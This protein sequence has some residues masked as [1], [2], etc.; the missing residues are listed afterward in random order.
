MTGFGHQGQ[1][2]GVAI[3]DII[4]LHPDDA[5]RKQIDCLQVRA[6]L[7]GVH[8]NAV[9]NRELVRVGKDWRETARHSPAFEFILACLRLIA[10]LEMRVM[11]LGCEILQSF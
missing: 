5:R 1:S 4:C 6:T 11:L 8:F 9:V 10:G 3:V 7:P 2:R